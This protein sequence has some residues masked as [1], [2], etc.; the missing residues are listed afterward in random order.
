M[1]DTKQGNKD[2]NKSTEEN[3]L[4]IP[5]WLNRTF[6]EKSLRKY[7]AN[8]SL[9]MDTFRIE[10]AIPKGENFSSAMF[11]VKSTCTGISKEVNNYLIYF[12]YMSKFNQF[13]QKIGEPFD[14]IVKLPYESGFG[15]DLLTQMN[16]YDK[17]LEVY[18]K[19]LPRLTTLLHKH[20]IFEDLFA[21]TFNVSYSKKAIVFED[22]SLKQYRMPDKRGA[23]DETHAKM[24]LRKLAIYHAAAAQL[25]QTDRSAYKNFNFG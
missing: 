6:L 5:E 18:D 16:V 22:L 17:E 2:N 24:L 1:A 12:L 4:I 15:L 23:L 3:Y 14:F 7:F 13:M 25:G 21:R 11:R 20:G 8:P 9:T 19:I 10:P